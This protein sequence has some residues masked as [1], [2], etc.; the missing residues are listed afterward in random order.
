LAVATLTR[1]SRVALLTYLAVFFVFGLI[2]PLLLE[3]VTQT[4]NVWILSPVDA[5]LAQ[6]TWLFG[7]PAEGI[8]F[9]MWWGLLEIVLVTAAA[10]TV[11][12]VRRPRV[13][14]EEAK[15]DA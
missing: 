5:M 10:W 8:E 6:A 11:F 4:G 12:L 9:P 1:S 7:Y 2:L 15:D 13:K 14:G 3:G